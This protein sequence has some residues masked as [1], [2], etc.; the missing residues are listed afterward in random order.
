MR[1]AIALQEPA[2]QDCCSIYCSLYM[3]EHSKLNS[4][5]SAPA[6]A[7]RIF[8]PPDIS[9]DY[10]MYRPTV[11]TDIY[12]RNFNCHCYFYCVRHVVNLVYTLF[13]HCCFVATVFTVFP[14]DRPLFD[15]KSVQLTIA[16]RCALVQGHSRSSTFVAIESP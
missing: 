10:A 1:T 3:K 11:C 6:E 5:L 8:A 2:L 15:K 9:R 7:A 13:S 16:D 12:S 4:V 14:C